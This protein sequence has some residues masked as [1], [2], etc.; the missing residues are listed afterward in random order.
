MKDLVEYLAKN[1]VENP[2]EVVVT[3]EFDGQRHLIHLDVA[4]ADMGKVIGRGGRVAEAMRAVLKVSAA[5]Q[6]TRAALDIGD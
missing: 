2:D 3:E 1:L 4:E 5:R 6:D